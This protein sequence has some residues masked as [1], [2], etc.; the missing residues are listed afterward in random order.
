F[1]YILT[2]P[3]VIIIFLIGY[4]LM[5]QSAAGT[6]LWTPP[7]LISINASVFPI[8]IGMGL[9]LIIPD[10]IKAFREFIG[11][12]GLGVSIG[13]GTFFGGVGT[14]WAGAQTG[15]G[16]ITSFAQF[17]LI[18]KLIPDKLKQYIAPPTFSEALRSELDPR[19]LKKR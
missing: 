1:A 4:A 18:N 14:A 9:L 11:A 12:K 5:Q 7:F 16:Q 8:L 3:L 17:P 6:Q 10:L 15:L 2:F 13:I 19:L